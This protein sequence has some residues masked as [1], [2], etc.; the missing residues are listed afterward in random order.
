MEITFAKMNPTEN[1]TILV[2]SSL[3]REQY[4]PIAARLMAYGS[5]FA[6]QVGYIEKPALKGA[7]SRLHMMGGEFCGNATMSTAALIAFDDGVKGGEIVTVPLE[8]SGAEGLLRCEVCPSAGEEKTA[9]VSL[10]MPPALGV[11]K[12]V[13]QYD[14]ASFETHMVLT[15]GITH[16]LIDTGLDKQRPWH[17]IAE[18]AI[19][20]WNET[21]KADALGIMLFEPTGDGYRIEPLVYVE[22]SKSLTWERGCGSG[23]AAMGAYLAWKSK[24]PIGANIDQPGGRIRVEADYGDNGVGKITIRG[25]VKLAA[26][27]TAYL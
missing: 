9:A 1:M 2:E 10:G 22:G 21:L 24:S 26:R 23:T 8:V 27:G 16:L 6:E 13:F 12:R 3:P 4:G 5:L 17:S 19:I 14:G 7:R 18:G 11:E 20:Q 25:I 15:E